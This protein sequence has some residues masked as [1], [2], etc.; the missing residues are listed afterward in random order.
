MKVYVNGQLINEKS[1]PGGDPVNT[2][3]LFIGHHNTSNQPNK[4]PY[5]FIGNLDDARIYKQKLD[6]DQVL[7]LYNE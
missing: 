1:I 2:F 5:Y 4:F 7:A 6:S 3:D